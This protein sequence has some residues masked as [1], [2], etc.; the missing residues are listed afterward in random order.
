[1]RRNTTP[2]II[3]LALTCIARGSVAQDAGSCV[4]EVQRLDEGLPAVHDQASAAALGREPGARKGASLGEDQRR[5][6][7]ALIEQARSAGK[8]GDGG[9][10]MQ[11]LT[12]ARELLREAGL[13]AGQPGIASDTRLGTE[14][15]G[16]EAPDVVGGPILPAPPSAVRVPATGGATTDMGP[17][18]AGAGAAGGAGTRGGGAA[19]APRAVRQAAVR[20]G[21]QA[22]AVAPAAKTPAA[23]SS[24]GSSCVGS[25]TC[26][27]ISTLALFQSRRS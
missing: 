10:C 18:A 9:R 20:A 26:P 17:A 14:R 4:D 1:M 8:G 11:S 21:R 3:A 16:I 2:W 19:A 25:S 27:T 7:S 13:G 23:R 5:Q 6:V 12:Q 24:V 15:L 22:V